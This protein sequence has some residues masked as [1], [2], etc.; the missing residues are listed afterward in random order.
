MS[1]Q[2]F[3]IEFEGGEIER[4]SNQKLTFEVPANHACHITPAEP[5]T[6]ASFTILR[7]ASGTGKSS[8]VSCLYSR[9]V[10]QTPEHEGLSFVFH[11]NYYGGS[12]VGYVPQDLAIVSHWRMSKIVPSDTVFWDC[13]F[14]P[15]ATPLQDALKRRLGQYSG[16]QQARILTISVAERLHRAQASSFLLLDEALDGLGAAAVGQVTANLVDRWTTEAGG[17]PLHVVL[18]THLDPNIVEA[19]H[20]SFNRCELSER[21]GSTEDQKVIEGT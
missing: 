21:P 19:H 11:P 16:G 20:S 14:D 8:I 5:N 13:F 1:D 15:A 3:R 18:V 7:G 4:Q 12:H 2:Y 6:R 10:F 17:L 9:I